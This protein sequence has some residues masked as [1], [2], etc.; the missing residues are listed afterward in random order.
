LTRC[1]QDGIT[2][3]HSVGRLNLRTMSAGTKER[4]EMRVDE[5]HGWALTTSRQ[6][7]EHLKKQWL[8]EEYGHMLDK[9]AAVMRARRQKNKDKEAL[10]QA[11][12]KADNLQLLVVAAEYSTKE[13]ER[14][15]RTECFEV[16]KA[17]RR[18]TQLE[19]SQETLE[20]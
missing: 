13:V 17:L 5:R 2:P 20:T 10:T 19:R 8:E 16:D 6:E 12:V 18:V 11:G 14:H 3:V 1:N 15:L 7:V 9:E 4:L